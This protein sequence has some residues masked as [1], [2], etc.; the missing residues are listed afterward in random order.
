MGIEESNDKILYKSANI[1]RFQ[2]FSMFDLS[3]THAQVYRQVEHVQRIINLPYINL[4]VS[5]WRYLRREGEVWHDP[6]PC[7]TFGTQGTRIEGFFDRTRENW[8]VLFSTTDLRPGERGSTVQ[9][10]YRDNWLTI[11]ALIPLTPDQLPGWRSEF[12]HICEAMHNPVPQN[13]MR[14]ELGVMNVLRFALDYQLPASRLLPAEQMK[15]VIDHDETCTQSLAELSIKCG[16]S[17]DHMRLLFRR[18]YQMSPQQYR[19]R[20]R[21]TLAME[22]LMNSTLSVKEVARQLGFVHVSHFSAAFRQV[23]GFPPSQ[24]ITRY[25]HVV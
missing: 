6:S 8:V 16:Y 22:L 19:L 23:H 14:A 24:V 21:M 5:G 7:I 25:R 11:P 15:A 3:I 12:Q 1:Y 10:R 2:V 13:V 18:H 17:V 4:A 20:R 9:V